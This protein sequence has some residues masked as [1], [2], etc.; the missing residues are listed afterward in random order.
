MK[1]KEGAL[2]KVVVTFKTQ[3]ILQLTHFNFAFCEINFHIT[4][5]S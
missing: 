4:V 3:T 1:N 2:K 5:N